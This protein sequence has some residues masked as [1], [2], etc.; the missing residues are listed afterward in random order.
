MQKQKHKTYNTKEAANYLQVS[1]STIYRYIKSEK[2]KASK[3][4][5]KYRIAYSSVLSLQS[6][7]ANKKNPKNISN[8]TFIDLFAG[9]GGFRIPFEKLGGKC[10]FSSEIDKF[11][12]ET[13]EYNFKDRCHGDIMKI[14]ANHIPEFD[15]LLA[16]FPCQPFSNAGLKKGF[17]DTRGT[18]FF[19]IARI[20]RFHRPKVV[21]LENV[22]GLQNHNKGQTLQTILRILKELE[23]KVFVQ[24]LNAKDFGIPQ[25]RERIYLVC[26]RNQKINFFFP[27]SQNVKTNLGSILEEDVN[28]KYTISD[29][30]WMGHQK[31][32]KNHRIKGNG[33]GY[34]LFNH[35]SPY[36]STISARYYK[37]GS[38]IL[39]A[40]KAQNPRKITP[41]EGLRLQGF[42]ESYK[43]PVSDTQAYKQIGN[44]VCIP[45]VYQIA[46]QIYNNL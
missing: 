3:V 27:Q 36:T 6:Q 5:G 20:I 7:I 18:L 43:F 15:I 24:V 30:L 19:E 11:A 10:V 32:K 46:K 34:R 39:I 13:Y 16:G 28:K 21:F 31:R 14:P 12:R 25:N 37:D 35:D 38:E 2:L 44:S 41:R 45:V 26:F 23:Y 33:F 22:K 40:Q 8:F 1:M 4:Q 42:P 9:I 17:D 29:K